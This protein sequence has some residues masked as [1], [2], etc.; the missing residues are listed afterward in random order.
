[1]LYI[2]QMVDLVCVLISAFALSFL[3]VVK[4]II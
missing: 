2:S 3:T 4:F 1:M